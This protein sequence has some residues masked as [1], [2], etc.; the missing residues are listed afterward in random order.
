MKSAEI[1]TLIDLNILRKVF[2][3]GLSIEFFLKLE[4][5]FFKLYR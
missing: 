1:Y 5:F 2:F 4:L 3:I